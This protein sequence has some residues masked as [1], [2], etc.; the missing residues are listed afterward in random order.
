MGIIDGVLGD[1][2]PLVGLLYADRPDAA[3]NTAVNEFANITTASAC[4][5]C[6]KNV[7]VILINETIHTDGI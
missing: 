4:L 3:L 6:D 1:A 2:W 7:R 5:M